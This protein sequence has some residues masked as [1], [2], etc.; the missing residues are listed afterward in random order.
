MKAKYK[1]CLATPIV[2]SLCKA[3]FTW[4]GNEEPQCPVAHI[5]GAKDKI[6]YPP[7]YSAKILSDGAHLIAISHEQEVADFVKQ[8]I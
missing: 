5:H 1:K 8:N 4:E 6:I 7:Q 2:A 3:V